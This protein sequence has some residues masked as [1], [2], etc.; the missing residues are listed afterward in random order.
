M[1]KKLVYTTIYILLANSLFQ[2]ISDFTSRSMGKE[3]DGGN[4]LLEVIFVAVCLLFCILANKKN[5]MPKN[6]IWLTVFLSYV[7]LISIVHGFVIGFQRRVAVFMYAQPL[8]LYFVEYNAQQDEGVRKLSP[9]C[10][11]ALACWILILFLI[12]YR[13]VELAMESFFTTN[14]SY[15]LLYFLPMLF[16]F[17]KEK[18]RNYV[19]LIALLVVLLSSKRAGILAIGLG[20][21]SYRYAMGR[22]SSKK[23]FIRTLLLIVIFYFIL[24]RMNTIMGGRIFDRFGSALDD[25]GSGRIDVWIQT[26]SLIKGSD[27]YHWFFGH[28]FNS[29]VR[30]MSMDFSAHND[31]LEIF[32]DFGLLGLVLFVA[33]LVSWFVAVGKKI[34]LRSKHAPIVM[35]A[36][37]IFI[38]NCFFSHIV[39]YT[40]NFNLFAL[41]FGAVLGMEKREALV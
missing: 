11:K 14:T 30:E 36:L 41:F 40:L 23:G 4:P 37:F 13:K 32:F 22:V 39:I 18:H 12:N 5:K 17:I 9:Y 2:S 26:W 7:L 25:S 3:I 38:T 6:G 33:F 21:L 35:M 20:F 15:Y 29:L 19:F 8:L 16:L 10:V 27:L 24:I 31:F 1:L 28:G 34:K